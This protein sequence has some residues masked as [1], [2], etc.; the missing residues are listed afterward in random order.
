MDTIL[1]QVLKFLQRGY[2][3]V[4]LNARGCGGVPLST[5]QS[6]A[7]DRALDIQEIIENIS[8]RMR[9]LKISKP[10]FLLGF[11]LGK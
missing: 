11:S 8:H 7:G 2:E 4:V 1:F 5:S 10:L 3:V 6:F 9:H